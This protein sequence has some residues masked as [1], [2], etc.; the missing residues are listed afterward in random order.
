MQGEN[1]SL[2]VALAP[3]DAILVAVALVGPEG[4][5]SVAGGSAASF[6]SVLGGASS[7]SSTNLSV[8]FWL[9]TN[10]SGPAQVR[11]SSSVSGSLSATAIDVGRIAGV[12]PGSSGTTHGTSVHPSLGLRAGVGDLALVAIVTPTGNAYA[13]RGHSVL[14]TGE[15]GGASGV[16]SLAVVARVARHGG[17]LALGTVLAAPSAFEAAGLVLLPQPFRGSGGGP[18]PIWDV[19]T[20]YLENSDLGDVQ[21]LGNGSYFHYLSD[22]YL[23][24]DRTFS[25]CHP[26]APNYLALLGG[27][28]LQCGSDGLNP[29]AYSGS[30]LPSLLAAAGFSWGGYFESAA[31]ACSTVSSGAYAAWHDPFV[32]FAGI[33]DGASTCQSHVLNSRAFNASLSSNHSLPAN[34]SFYGPNLNDDGH[35][36]GLAAADSWLRSFLGPILNSTDPVLRTVLQHTLFLLTFDES[37]GNGAAGTVGDGSGGNR[38]SFDSTPIHGLSGGNVWTVLVSPGGFVLPGTYSAAASAF[39]LQRTIEWLFGI[40]GPA[41]IGREAGSGALTG[42]F[43]FNSNGYGP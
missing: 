39:G 11:I 16:P 35:D 31:S 29:G 37:D 19:V 22:R 40:P 43:T 2:N 6:T 41:S 25:V 26:S 18:H 21:Q 24:A 27:R 30:T 23:L 3:G 1:L 34:F 4:T 17:P 36:T 28:V 8:S 5:V 10:A 38:T 12:G 15:A 9:A 33:Y 13:P 14:L 42:A 20:L 32:Y 7:A